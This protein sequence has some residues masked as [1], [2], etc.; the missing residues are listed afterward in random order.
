MAGKNLG[1]DPHHACADEMIDIALDGAAITVQP[2][3]EPRDR[4][5]LILGGT[6]NYL[7]VA[8]ALGLA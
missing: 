5:R 3:R 4:G 8:P 1:L 6:E 2:L 7:P